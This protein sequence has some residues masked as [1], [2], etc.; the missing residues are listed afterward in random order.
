M[1]DNAERRGDM[2]RYNRTAVE[3]FFIDRCAERYES[4]FRETIEQAGGK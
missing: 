4:L 3:E 1:H 2:A